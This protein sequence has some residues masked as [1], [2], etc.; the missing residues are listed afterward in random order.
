MVGKNV[1]VRGR[2]SGVFV[3]ILKKIEGTVV[4]L[5][6]CRRLWWWSGASSISEVATLGVSRPEQCKFPG[7]VDCQLVLDAIEVIPMTAVAVTSVMGV[8][9]WT[10]F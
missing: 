2:D 6:D 1:L 8:K 5:A 3:G 4:E 10:Q 9:P 7:P